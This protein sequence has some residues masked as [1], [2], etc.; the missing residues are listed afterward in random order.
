MNGVIFDLSGV[1]VDSIPMHYEAWKNAFSE[2]VNF[3]VNEGAIYLFEG[4]RGIELVNNIPMRPGLKELD[5]SI[6]TQ[7]TT[8]KGEYFRKVFSFKPF[9]RESELV[10]NLLS[11]KALVSSSSK[12]DADSILDRAIGFGKELFDV[13]ITADVVK[14][15][16]PDP[17]LLLY[18]LENLNLKTT[19][20]IVIENAPL[21]VEAA[22]RA[23]TPSIVVLNNTPLHAV[24]FKPLV[25]KER[26]LKRTEFAFNFL[27]EWCNA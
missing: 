3:E 11:H 12:K 25:L 10:T 15:G 4:T 22:N 21:G 8:R 2:K 1:L 24:N 6:V 9:E 19:G 18:A 27:R 26:I 14:S 5:E 7:I 17:S 20:S 13:I 23:G 16:K